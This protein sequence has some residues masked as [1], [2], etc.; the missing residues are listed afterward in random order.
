MNPLAISSLASAVLPFFTTARAP[1][2][3]QVDAALAQQRAAEQNAWLMGG[4]IGG[5]ALVVYL[6]ARPR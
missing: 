1:S 3:A 6:L 5:V 4:A 2:Q